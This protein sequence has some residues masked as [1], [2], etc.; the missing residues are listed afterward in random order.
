MTN[1]IYVKEK[2]GAKQ[3]KKEFIQTGRTVDEA[4]QLAC[5]SLGV[6]REE[7]EVQ[8]LELPKKGLFGNL[9]VPAKISVTY[10]VSKVKTAVEYIE[11]ILTNMGIRDFEIKVKEE[12]ESAEISLEG[13]DLGVVI[14]RRGETLDAIQYLCSLVANRETGEYFRITIDSG[15]FRQK[16]EKT[17]ENLAKKLA[18][19]ALKSGRSITLEPM[20]PYERRIIHSTVGK[21]NG[22]T[23]T[24]IGDEPNRRVVIS[25]TVKRPPR[26]NNRRPGGPGGQ[27]GK[28]PYPN[29]GG[30]PRGKGGPRP[31]R[32]HNMKTSTSL[33]NEIKTRENAFSQPPTQPRPQTQPQQQPQERKSAPTEAADKPLYSKIDID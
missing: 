8:I 15:D 23:S 25:S 13:P 29:K 18:N 5:E 2:G 27:G 21:I 26:P 7:V 20:N 24:S 3:L 14:G 6:S 30:A 33:G 19:N 22:V 12:E 16:R 9:K 32:S 31:P 17:L 11:Q 4:T 28:R 10:E 1:T